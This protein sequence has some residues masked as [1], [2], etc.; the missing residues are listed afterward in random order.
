M[1]LWSTVLLAVLKAMGQK[2]HLWK[3]WQCFSWMWLFSKAKVRWMTPQWMHLNDRRGSGGWRSDPEVGLDKESWRARTEA[4]LVT[5]P[6]A[7]SL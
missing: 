2:A 5:R 3:T 6:R 1:V 7:L 4:S